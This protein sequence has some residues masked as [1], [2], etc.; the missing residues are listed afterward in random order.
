MYM[1]KLISLVIGFGIGA[2]LG[3]GIVVLF[4]PA[5]G[6]KL[7]KLLKEGYADTLEEARTA[8][9]NRRKELEAELKHR[10]NEA[11]TTIQKVG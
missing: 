10:R 6:E 5:S 2:A 11:T 4:A 1:K 8:A 9:E 3:A 7:I